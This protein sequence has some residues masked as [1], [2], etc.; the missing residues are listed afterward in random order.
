MTTED[1]KNKIKN[2]TKYRNMLGGVERTGNVLHIYYGGNMGS[3]INGSVNQM[4]KNLGLPTIGFFKS[5]YSIIK[6]SGSPD[7]WW[8]LYIKIA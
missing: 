8:E 1:I 3:S 7:Y 2:K 5:N 4:M 6:E